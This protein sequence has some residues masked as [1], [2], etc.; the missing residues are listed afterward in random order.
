MMSAEAEVW[1]TGWRTRLGRRLIKLGKALASEAAV[2]PE[3][4]PL[5]PQAVEPE[6]SLPPAQA[7]DPEVSFPPTQ[8]Q[9]DTVEEV[10]PDKPPAEDQIRQLFYAALEAQTP[11]NLI[12]FVEFCNRFRRHSIFNARLIQTQRRGARACATAAEWHRTGRW[13]LPDAQPIIIL[14][15][16]GPTAH[17]YDIEDTGPV[18]DRAT[19]GDPFA[20]TTSVPVKKISEAIDRLVNGCAG[21]KQFHIE[22]VGERLGF[23]FAGSASAQGT[24]P[25]TLPADAAGTAHDK[26][27]AELA[28]AL[29]VSPA[30]AK[31][32]RWIP[33]WR[34]KMNDRMTPPEQL[35]TIAHELGHIFCG[36]LGGCGGLHDQSGWPERRAL[37]HHEKEMEAEAVAWLIAERAGVLSASAAYLR[38]HVEQGKT[39]Q[40]D[41]ALVAKAAGR[42]ES[43]AGLRYIQTHV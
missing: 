40:V 5:E 10:A 28:E 35:V 38:R 33:S 15:P 7:V 20:A 29:L 36:H 32:P 34:V 30:G 16:F 19:I 37:G 39:A 18:H 6:M 4:S 11:D 23:S 31:K 12:E 9:P 21:N 1:F 22:V 14:W 17:V 41:T 2:A 27:K 43:L 13:V 26:A 8:A 3:A 24:L 42:I 25:V